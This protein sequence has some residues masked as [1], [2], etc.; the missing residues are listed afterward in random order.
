M[1][2]F[3]PEN[4]NIHDLTIEEPEQKEEGFFDP[5]KEVTERD[6]EGIWE[7]F[8]NEKRGGYWRE[9][10]GMGANIKIVDPGA[11]LGITPEDWGNMK[12][13]F[14]DCLSRA[15]LYGAAIRG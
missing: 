15:D 3:N 6:W 10:V 13:L 11:D 9:V 5:E 7:M 8:E 2:G 1:P 12:R 4:I 14:S